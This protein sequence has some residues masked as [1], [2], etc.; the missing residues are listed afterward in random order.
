MLIPPFPPPPSSCKLAWGLRS[1]N[2]DLF[3][4][5]HKDSIAK[6]VASVEVAWFCVLHI[7]LAS[8]IPTIFSEQGLSSNKTLGKLVMECRE[9][10]G[11]GGG[12]FL[13]RKHQQILIC[14]DLKNRSLQGHSER[15]WD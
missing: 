3:I 8:F 1:R 15:T 4:W 10:Q 2:F 9:E 12:V 13:E 7:F 6:P 5:R 14:K 11:Q